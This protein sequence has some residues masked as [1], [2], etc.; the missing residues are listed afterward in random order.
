MVLIVK[1]PDVMMMSE[2]QR[3]GVIQSSFQNV[4]L[5]S[6]VFLEGWMVKDLIVTSNI[7]APIYKMSFFSRLIKIFWSTF[8][9]D[10]SDVNLLLLGLLSHYVGF[11]DIF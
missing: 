11:R 1:R 4:D 5:K 2:F 6:E 9:Y 10:T 8:R 7:S 3:V